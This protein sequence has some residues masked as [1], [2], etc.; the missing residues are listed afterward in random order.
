MKTFA[1]DYSA[2]A[3]LA[4]PA[5]LLAR[6]GDQYLGPEAHAVFAAA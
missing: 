6:C 5:Q 3:E 1:V 4:E 2:E